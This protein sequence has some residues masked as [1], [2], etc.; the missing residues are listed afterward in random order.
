MR[1]LVFLLTFLFALTAHSQELELK[2]TTSALFKEI[3]AVDKISKLKSGDYLKM[4]KKSKDTLIS[5][6][7]SDGQKSGVWRYFSKDNMLWMS[8]D[9][10]KNAFV[11][12]PE[13]LSRIDSFA[14]RKD[15]SF[16]YT[17]VD[18]PPVYLGSKNEIEKILTANFNVPKEIIENEESEISMA[19]FIVD[20]NGK[21]NE[22]QSVKMLY[23]EVFTEMKNALKFVDGDWTPAIADGKPVDSQILLVCDIT[24][25]GAKSLFRDNPK[26]IIIHAKYSVVQNTKKSIGFGVGTE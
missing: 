14:V 10:G 1:I 18:M 8:Y 16:S 24:Q 5:G 13:D 11:V 20:K 17:K 4:D 26:A 6:T 21:I 25:Q 15:D 7:Y 2:K 3:Y 9:F 23:S 19:T 22:F 12:I